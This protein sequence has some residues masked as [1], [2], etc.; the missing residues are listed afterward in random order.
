ME[1]YVQRFQ[2]DTER[3]IKGEYPNER[4][5]SDNMRIQTMNSFPEI[6][7]L[8]EGIEEGYVKKAWHGTNL[9][10]SIRGLSA[11]QAAVRP[12]K[13]RHN[14]WEIVVHCAYWKYAVWRRITG[15]KRGSFPLKGSNWFP[16]PAENSEQAWRGDV[17]LLNEMHELMIDAV[18]RLRPSDLKKVPKG[19]NVDNRSMI[20]GIAAHDIYHAGQIQLI[21]RMVR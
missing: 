4:A 19:S 1:G 5:E 11:K 9:R 2:K 10:G 12:G 18:A 13:N 6:R 8:L 3:S 14:I 20:F 21:K 17:G 7:L 16:R 15:E